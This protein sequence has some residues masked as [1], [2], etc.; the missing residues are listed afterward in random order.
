MHAD[1][2]NVLFCDV[3]GNNG[4]SDETVPSITNIDSKSY[5]IYYIVI[6]FYILLGTTSNDNTTVLLISDITSTTDIMIS[7]T[8]TSGISNGI[9]MFNADIAHLLFFSL[10]SIYF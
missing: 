6:L 1:Y 7:I 4:S 9:Y 2:S 3:L 10:L 8:P 5:I